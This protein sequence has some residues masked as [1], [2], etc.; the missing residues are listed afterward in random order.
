MM[1]WPDSGVA[2]FSQFES[3]QGTQF[4]ADKMNL[5]AHYLQVEMFAYPTQFVTFIVIF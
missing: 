4:Y 2:Q 5:F 3:L 1:H